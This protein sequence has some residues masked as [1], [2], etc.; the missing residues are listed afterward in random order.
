MPAERAYSETADQPALAALFDMQMARARST[1]FDKC[2][3]E[4]SRLVQAVCGLEEEPS[5]ME[6]SSGASDA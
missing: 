5:T 2:Y 1:S 3:R 6:G 4:I